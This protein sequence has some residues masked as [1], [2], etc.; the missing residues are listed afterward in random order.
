[1][2]WWDDVW[3]NEAFANYAADYLV[4]P[5]IN[6]DFDTWLT[7]ENRH[8]K[9]SMLIDEKNFTHPIVVPIVDE[10]QLSSAFD[11]ITYDKGSNGEF[12]SDEE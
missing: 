6:P 11:Q 9:R 7:A 12:N 8:V 3:L 2:E 1:M 4:A 10:A 5:I